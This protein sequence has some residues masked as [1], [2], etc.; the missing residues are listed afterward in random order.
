[1]FTVMSS[2]YKADKEAQY[3]DSVTQRATNKNKKYEKSL[4]SANEVDVASRNVTVN[5]S[6]PDS[7]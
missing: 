4:Y 5:I 2:Q 3:K 1:M 7:V 6:S